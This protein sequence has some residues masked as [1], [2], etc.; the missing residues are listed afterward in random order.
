MQHEIGN[1][2]VLHRLAALGAI[3]YR[4]MFKGF[5]LFQEGRFFGLLVNGQLYLKTAPETVGPYLERGMAAFNPSETTR[6][7][8][9]HQVPPDVLEDAEQLC[10][11]AREAVAVSKP[12][13]G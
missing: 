10:T 12:A 7:T 6:L 1:Y 8:T 5:G 9:Y 4:P 11:W 13:E 2:L 3:D